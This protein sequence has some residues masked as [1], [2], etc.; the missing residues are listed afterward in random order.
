MVFTVKVVTPDEYKAHLEDL[1]RR[2]Q[3]GAATGGQDAT[4]IPGHP[5]KEGE[6]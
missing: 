5:A 2:G 1:A 6:K 3:T 4:T